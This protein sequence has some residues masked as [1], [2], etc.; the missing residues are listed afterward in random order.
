MANEYLTNKLNELGYSVRSVETD[1]FL[2]DPFLRI[3]FRNRTLTMS[4]IEKTVTVLQN[5]TMTDQK[6]I[7]GFWAIEFESNSVIVR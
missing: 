1:Y 2:E 6:P 4:E 7:K 3:T 5:L